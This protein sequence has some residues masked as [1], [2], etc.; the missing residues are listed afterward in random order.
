[1]EKNDYTLEFSGLKLGIHNFS[2]EIDEQLFQDRENHEILKAKAKADVL[3]D[4]RETFM[5]LTVTITGDVTVICD[6]CGDETEIPIST[7]EKL[8]IKLNQEDFENADEVIVVGDNDYKVDLSQQLYEFAYLS[9]PVS[10][11]HPLGENE[12]L[13]CD[14]EKIKELELLLQ[15]D[16]EIQEEQID[17][18]WSALKDLLTDKDENHGAS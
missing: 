3:M 10:R 17:E 4:K 11:T 15:G 16:S 6:R 1:V 18:R 13:T 8:W 12:E 9:I 2:Y 7:E 14:P 5:E